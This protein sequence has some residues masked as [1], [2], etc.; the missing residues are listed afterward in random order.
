[1][2]RHKA[3]FLEQAR[4]GTKDRDFTDPDPLDHQLLAWIRGIESLKRA[5]N[6][7][8]GISGC[9]V[10]SDCRIAVLFRDPI[11]LRRP[12]QRSTGQSIRESRRGCRS[13]QIQGI[14]SLYCLSSFPEHPRT[15]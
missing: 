3:L 11:I 6:S 10:L 13:L 8:N 14:V 1:M 9:P 15:N 4:K 12:L 5:D 2:L 7:L